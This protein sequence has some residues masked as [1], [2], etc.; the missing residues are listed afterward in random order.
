MRAVPGGEGIAAAAV[1]CDDTK[2]RLQLARST[3]QQQIIANRF[4][5]GSL[6]GGQYRCVLRS[7][8]DGSSYG[9]ACIVSSIEIHGIRIAKLLYLSIVR[10]VE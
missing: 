6:N 5:R 4:K 2:A 10:K 3:Q 1:D 9:T 8:H 7:V